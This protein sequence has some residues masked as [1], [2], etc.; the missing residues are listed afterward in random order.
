[1]VFLLHGR[2]RVEMLTARKARQT[3]DLPFKPGTPMK[4]SAGLGDFYGTL[5]GKVVYKEQGEL[6]ARRKK[7]D[8]PPL[9]PNI[10]TNPGKKVSCG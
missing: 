7:G 4:K 3:T 1:M 5:G 10:L 6:N 8:F 2:V 9:P